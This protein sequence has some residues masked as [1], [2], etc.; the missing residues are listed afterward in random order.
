MTI[1]VGWEGN[2]EAVTGRT[3][4]TVLNFIKILYV[5]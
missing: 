4:K 3:Q 1:V 2:I 5:P